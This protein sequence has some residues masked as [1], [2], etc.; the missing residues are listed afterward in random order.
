MEVGLQSN[1]YPALSFYSSL[2][3]RG[4]K[5]TNVSSCPSTMRVPPAALDALSVVTADTSYEKAIGKKVMSLQP[6]YQTP[7]Y[8]PCTQRSL[9]KSVW[10]G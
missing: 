9:L 6:H 3:R 10:S 4:V 7:E 1:V 2:E 5:E 8:H